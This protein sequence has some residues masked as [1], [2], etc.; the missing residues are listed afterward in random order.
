M[1]LILLTRMDKVADEAQE[2]EWSDVEC[3]ALVRLFVNKRREFAR[4]ILDATNREEA[5]GIL[6]GMQWAWDKRKT[7]PDTEE[8]S[9]QEAVKMVVDSVSAALMDKI[10]EED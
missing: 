7:K 10:Q 6:K 2:E 5:V 4:W 9:I 3:P 1:E 8:R